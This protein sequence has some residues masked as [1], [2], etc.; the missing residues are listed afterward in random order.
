MLA[1]KIKDNGKGFDPL[2]M[3]GK[4]NGLINMKKR[5]DEIKGHYEII[6]GFAKGTSVRIGY[7]LKI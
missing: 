1:I 6:S 5:M 3:N 2:M 4:G 7:N